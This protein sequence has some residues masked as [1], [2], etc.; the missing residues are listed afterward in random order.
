MERC[1]FG[2][3]W[4]VGEPVE[5]AEDAADRPWLLPFFDDLVCTKLEENRFWLMVAKKF[6]MI[7]MA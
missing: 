2:V 3:G 7:K 1:W 4:G 6:L 5:V